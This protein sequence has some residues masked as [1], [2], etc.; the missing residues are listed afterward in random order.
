M[1]ISALRGRFTGHP[2]SSFPEQVGVCSL[3]TI[4]TMVTIVTMVTILL[5]FTLPT[6]RVREPRL[7]VTE[8]FS[9]SSF[10]PSK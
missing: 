8:L 5:F 9:K 1:D 10:N 7:W 4:L 2:A 6:C 3:K